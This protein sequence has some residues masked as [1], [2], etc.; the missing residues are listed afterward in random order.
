MIVYVLSKTNEEGEMEAVGVLRDIKKVHPSE[1]E[2]SEMAWFA[3]E[4]EENGSLL[5][6][7]VVGENGMEIRPPKHDAHLAIVE[8]IAHLV[9]DIMQEL[10]ELSPNLMNGHASKAYGS[11]IAIINSLPSRHVLEEYQAELFETIKRKRGY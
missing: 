2:R 7:F 4:A 5:D 1:W 6:P 10:E 9:N 8:P 3:D 11:C